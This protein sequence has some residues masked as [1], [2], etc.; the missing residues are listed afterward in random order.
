MMTETFATVG[1]EKASDTW[2]VCVGERIYSEHDTKKNAI[3]EAKD[4]NSV[5]T[6]MAFTKGNSN[7][8]TIKA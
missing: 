4:I 3:Q 8:K 1:W 7:I 5:N 2:A 6:V